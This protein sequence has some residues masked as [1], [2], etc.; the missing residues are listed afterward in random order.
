VRQQI[1]VAAGEKIETKPKKPTGHAIEFRINAEDPHNN[2]RPSPGKI[3]SLHFPGGFGVRIDSHIYQSY[4]IPPYYDSLIAK[5]IVWGK[6]RE[7]AIMRGKRALNEFTVEGI[8]TTIPFH[9]Q[10]LEDERFKSGI[11]DTS[12]LDKFDYSS[13]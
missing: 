2:F 5:L 11:F 8:K 1:L 3:S 12:F 9:L 6:N 13:L 7:H 10:V 4:T